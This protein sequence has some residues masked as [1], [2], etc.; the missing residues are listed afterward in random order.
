MAGLERPGDQTP[1]QVGML[2]RHSWK[3]LR[4]Q[5]ALA[6][7]LLL[8]LPLPLQPLSHILDCSWW[9]HWGL[10]VWLAILGAVRFTQSDEGLCLFL[11]PC[12]W[13][14]WTLGSTNGRRFQSCHVGPNA[15]TVFAFTCYSLSPDRG[16]QQTDLFLYLGSWSDLILP[17]SSSSGWVWRSTTCSFK[18]GLD[19][20]LGALVLLPLFDSFYFDFD[21]WLWI[22]NY[23]VFNTVD[24]WRQGM[25]FVMSSEW[26]NQILHPDLGLTLRQSMF[27]QVRPV[28]SLS[29]S[30]LCCFGLHIDPVDSLAGNSGCRTWQCFKCAGPHNRFLHDSWWS[31]A[32]CACA[33]CSL[34]ESDLLDG[35]TAD[36][37]KFDHLS[38]YVVAFGEDDALCSETDEVCG[39]GWQ[40]V[41]WRL[42]FFNQSNANHK[43]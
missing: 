31:S 7:F 24:G 23:S 14:A 36:E 3:P 21:S 12:I 26:V 5:R 13:H 40:A 42:S 37:S 11:V 25:Q 38:H 29:L 32:I 18:P 39:L 4:S 17:T 15:G 33:A 6:V 28:I 35:K 27:Q 22:L 2:Q 10:K 41:C 30:V 16:L 34:Q 43:S 20:Q 9:L 19:S 8:Q 1:L